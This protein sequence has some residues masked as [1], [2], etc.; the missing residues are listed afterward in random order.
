MGNLDVSA[1]TYC[2]FKKFNL[3]KISDLIEKPGQKFFTVLTHQPKILHE[4]ETSLEKFGLY[5][6]Y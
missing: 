4:I 3:H 6:K 5:L 2:L 1:Q